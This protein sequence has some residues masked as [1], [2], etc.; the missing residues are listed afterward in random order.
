MTALHYQNRVAIDERIAL[1]GDPAARYGDRMDGSALS[2]FDAAERLYRK[3][4]A[5]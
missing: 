3:A 4:F 5:A 2:G 1:V